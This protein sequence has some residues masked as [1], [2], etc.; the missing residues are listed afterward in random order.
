M[1]NIHDSLLKKIL[2]IVVGICVLGIIA[3]NLII[4]PSFTKMLI[5][6]TESEA[7]MVGKHMTPI[8]STEDSLI[9]DIQIKNNQ[10]NIE[11][12]INEFSLY[13]LKVFVASGKTIFSTD[14]KDIGITNRHEYFLN[15]VAKGCI[16][17]KVV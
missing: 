9:N 2:V 16:Y 14:K 12:L 15:D 17:T 7:V 4:Y 8:I 3:S 6:Y 5:K 11:E 10:H 1:I 13:K